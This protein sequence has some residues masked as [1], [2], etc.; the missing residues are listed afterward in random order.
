VPEPA[1]LL[2]KTICTTLTAVPRS[3]GMRCARR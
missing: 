1:P 3:S 2:P